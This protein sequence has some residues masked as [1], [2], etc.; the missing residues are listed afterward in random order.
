VSV[1]SADVGFHLKSFRRHLEARS[2]GADDPKLR[3][4]G[5]PAL[6]V[7]GRQRDADRSRV[8]RARARRG[9]DCACSLV[10]RRSTSMACG[11]SRAAR[12]PEVFAYARL[13]GN[14]GMLDRNFRFTP[15]G[16]N[17]EPQAMP[18]RDG[19]LSGRPTIDWS[20][21]VKHH[22]GGIARA[23]P[24][25]LSELLGCRS[26][27]LAAELIALVRRHQPTPDR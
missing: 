8:H 22:H 10:P 11:I 16:S 5:I 20:L 4:I 27:R 25:R 13:A 15:A 19:F 3:G 2:L 9:M 26:P 7:P 6:G 1:T 24:R 23:R 21:I 12:K 17:T 14:P 18:S